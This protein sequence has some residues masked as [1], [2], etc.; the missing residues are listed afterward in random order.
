MEDPGLRLLGQLLD[1]SHDLAPDAL[2]AA[3]TRA[4][5]AMDADDVAIYLVD[6]EQTLLVPLADGSDRPPLEIDATLAGRA[7][8]DIA[9]Q[10]ADTKAGRRLC[11]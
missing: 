10:E 9:V 11:R 2:A 7:F 4:A 6:Y 5:L 3:V 1:A 8:A